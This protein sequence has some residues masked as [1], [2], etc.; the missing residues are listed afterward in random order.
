MLDK[1]LEEIARQERLEYFR[2]WRANNKDK[3][4]QHNKNYWLRKAEQR[5][6][7]EQKDKKIAPWA[8]THGTT[9]QLFEN[10]QNNRSLWL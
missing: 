4:K 1:N 8:A 10:T 9:E 6:N 3:V 2:Q 7:E 5:L